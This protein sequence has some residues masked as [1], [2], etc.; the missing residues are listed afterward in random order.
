MSRISRGAAAAL[1]A[2]SAASPA[3]A[4]D[5]SPGDFVA[6]PAGTNLF[7]LYLK[8]VASGDLHNR[9]S[10]D[11]PDSE[12]QTAVSLLRFARYIE[13]GGMPAAVQAI[14][15]IGAIPEARVGGVDQPTKDGLGDI[16]FAAALFP[17]NTAMTEPYGSSLATTLYVTAPTGAYDPG[18]VSLGS[19]TWTLTPQIGL[20]QNIGE[21]WFL[22]AAADVSFALDHTENGVRYERD[23]SYQLQAYVRRNVSDRVSLSVGYSGVFGGE[24]R[25]DGAPDGTQTRADQA[26]VVASMWMTPTTQIQGMIGADLG[27]R[28][29]FRQEV[30]AELR[31]VKLF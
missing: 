18:K 10:G 24:H 4:V 29:G 11:V 27:A 3:L 17:L 20:T 12:L 2:A 21:G 9:L 1:A 23:P 6:A 26:R 31:F 8:G 22:D 16:V 14:V 28:G 19:G 5:V 30:N 13:V 15:P 7:A 25:I